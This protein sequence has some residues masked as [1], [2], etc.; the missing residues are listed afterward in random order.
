MNPE[1]QRNLWLEASPRRLGWVAV[2]LVL[3]YGAALIAAGDRQTAQA[4]GSIA[5]VGAVVF[6]ACALIWGGRAAGFSVLTEIAERTW[7]FQRLSAL[8]PWQMTW[9]KLLGAPALASLAGLTGLVVLALAAPE[10]DRVSIP[11]V[12]GSAIAAAALLQAASLGAALVGVRKARAEGRLAHARGVLFGFFLSAFVLGNML[13]SGRWRSLVGGTG[14]SQ[15]GHDQTIWW[16]MPFEADVLI[17][18]WLT[19]FAAWAVVGAWRLMRLE[20]QLENSPIVWMVFLLFLAVWSAGFAQTSDSAWMVAVFALAGAT[21]A[22]AFTDPADKVR[23]RLFAG[24]MLHGDRTRLMTG[25]PAV[26]PSAAFAIVAAVAA[27]FFAKGGLAAL[28]AAAFMLRDL[29]LIAFFRFGPRPRRGDFAAVI[30]LALAYG[31]GAI[32]GGTLGG[33]EGASLFVLNGG[34]PMVS[35]I[36][37]LAQAAVIWTFALRRIRRSDEAPA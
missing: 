5:A 13:I 28:A 31:V 21:Y 20:L 16:G 34:M 6:I 8:T 35:V 26:V 11:I 10:T 22:A 18:I 24:A 33:E 27:L 9:G 12:V 7:D 25:M 1:F 32:V 37:G 19:V 17:L 23:A 4:A 3:I 30:A 14:A 2:V 15:P 36:S 29:G